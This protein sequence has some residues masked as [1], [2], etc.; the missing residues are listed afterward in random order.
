[1]LDTLITSKTR[2]K[3]LMK[4]F[5]NSRTTSYL[6]DL[7]G[8]FGESTNAIRVELNRLEE[9]GLLRSSR[10]SNKKI[11]QAN[12]RHPLFGDI[13]SLLRKHTGM[14]QIIEQVVEKLGNVHSAFV[15]GHF[16]R[17]LDHD[18]IELLLVGED[19]DLEYLHRLI[20]RAEKTIGRRIKLVMQ[21]PAEAPAFLKAYPEAL[22]LWQDK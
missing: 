21:S 15:L 19:I 5:L 12:Q 2:V 17:G 7:E 20:D 14:D 1:M 10:E 3:L 18:T 6:R 4:F 9:A 8:E 11:Y 13:H 16:A 22:L